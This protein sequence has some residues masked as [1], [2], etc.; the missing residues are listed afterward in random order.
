M[1]SNSP[2]VKVSNRNVVFSKFYS[3]WNCD[4]N[5]GLILGQNR[6]FIIDTGVGSDSVAPLIEFLKSDAKPIVVINTHSHYDHVW[7]NFMFKDSLIIAHVKCMEYLEKS[8]DDDIKKYGDMIEGSTQKCL[9]NMT[10][11]GVL[12]FNDEGISIFN[13][14]GHAIDGISIYDSIDKVLY[15]GDEIG[16]TD[17][18]IVPQIHT[19]PEIFQKTIDMFKTIDFDICISGH[20]KPQKRDV[21]FRMEAALADS[22]KKQNEMR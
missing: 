13:S 22:W 10:F 12:N 2:G 5:I 16:D 21:L 11:D 3:Q 1:H 18:D 19:S 15:A 8:W 20:N 6:N 4:L 17:D 14:P 7:G 9:P